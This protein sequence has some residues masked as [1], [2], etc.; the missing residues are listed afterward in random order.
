MARCFG[1]RD[2][3]VDRRDCELRVTALEEQRVQLLLGGDAAAFEKRLD[4]DRRETT[5]RQF[6]LTNVLLSI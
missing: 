2:L 6:G 5:R 1:E 3:Q 4:T